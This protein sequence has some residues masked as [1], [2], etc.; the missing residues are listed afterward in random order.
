MV[1]YLAREHPIRFAHRGSRI[2]W[3][4]NTMEAFQKAVDLGYRYIET[5]VRITKDRVVVVFHDRTLER[6]TNGVGAVSDWLWEDLRHLDAAWTFDPDHDYPMRQHGVV[7]SR[8]DDVFATFPDINFNIDAKS[9]GLEWAVAD[10]ID[11]HDRAETTLLGS[12]ID[13]RAAKFR[14][15]TKG[16]I[17]TA[18]GPLAAL[19]M[20]TASRFG[21]SLT[22]PS[23][24]YQVPFDHPILRIDQKY[25]DAVH[26]AGD[27]IHCWTV[28]DPAEM[29][30]L[31]DLGVDGIISDRPDLLNEVVARRGVG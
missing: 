4:E 8:L 7:I 27:H 21:R 15:V 22:H 31:F 20:W 24:A 26:A 17:A 23:V 28:N 25:V 16:R 19:G 12:F 9:R 13:H 11:R 1:P 18:A 10:V 6:T 29:E 14:R 30:R 3:P 5:D 2:L